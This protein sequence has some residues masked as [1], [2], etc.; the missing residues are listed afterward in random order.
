MALYLEHFGLTEPPFRITPGTRFFFD[1]SQ[2]GEVLTALQYA[3]ESGAG[4]IKVVGEVGSGK[5]MLCRVLIERLPSSIQSIY[6]P[7]PTLTR[8]ELLIAISDELGIADSDSTTSTTRRLKAIQQQLL[9]A[10]GAGKQVVV[11]IDEAHAMP[12]QTLEELRLISNLETDDAKLLQIVLFGQPELDVNLSN[13]NMRQLRDRI[14]ESF[15]LSPLP[16]QDVQAYLDFRLRQAGYRGATLFNAAVAERIAQSAQGLTRRINVLADKTLLAAYA[17]G[18]HEVTLEHVSQALGEVDPPREGAP[19]AQLVPAKLSSTADDRKVQ[20]QD[21]PTSSWWSTAL[22]ALAATMIGALLSYALMSRSTSETA[23]PGTQPLV[24]RSLPAADKSADVAAAT[25]SPATTAPATAAP[26]TT[27]SAPRAALSTPSSTAA[28][29]GI[30]RKAETTPT[31]AAS[32]ASTERTA[33][34]L[35]PAVIQLVSA[36]ATDAK[37]LAALA[38]FA[39]TAEKSFSKARI[40][41]ATEEVRVNGVVSKR[42]ALLVNGYDSLP[43]ASTAIASLPQALQQYRPYAR[44]SKG[45]ITESRSAN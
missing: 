33:A 44:A 6:L 34:S 4:L 30:D 10:H 20:S 2:R 31:S 27:L 8:D 13:A 45:L 3:V 7:V 32:A 25:T 26:Q 1:G 23:V 5:T 43:A 11:L 42:V 35:S 29:I 15:H 37:A 17:A 21:V 36:N 38:S 41:Q 18:T 39:T 9:D 22:I 24:T 40:V 28:S 19:D 16:R 12:L 14:T